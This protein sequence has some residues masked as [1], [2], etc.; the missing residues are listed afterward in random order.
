MK[1]TQIALAIAALGLA[2]SVFAA[3]TIKIGALVPLS[4][5]SS[6]MG[7]AVRDGAR[8]AVKEINS[9]GGVL[10]KQ[11]ELVELDDEANADRAH[12][13]MQNLI[14]R[15]V[16]ASVSGINTGVVKSYEADVQAAKIPNIVPAATGTILT[17]MYKSAPEGNYTFRMNTP[18]NLQSLMMVERDV[19]K[20]YKKV[21]ILSDNTA[22]GKLGHEDLVKN[23]ASHGMKAVYEGEFAIKDNDMTA[24]LLKA[25]E[26]GADVINAYG[27]G[28]ELGHVAEGNTKLGLNLPIVTSWP[29]AMAPFVDIAKGA[30]NGTTSPQTFIE[31]FAMTAKGREFEKAYHAEYK[32]RPRILNPTATAGGYDSILLIAAAINQAKST[33]GA[34]IRDALENLNTP[35]QG[36]VTTFLK[37]F[38]KDDH[39]AVKPGTP[40]MAVWKDGLFV[41]APK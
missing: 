35:V 11:L 39:E 36:I 8:M 25:K 38:S 32:N 6:N 41:L 31:G 37:P 12:Q 34:K 19:A 22:Y 33:D 16:V 10:G 28:P 7:Q 29:S 18:D 5:G 26:A 24:Q 13:N 3:D 23:L 9:K 1:R 2:G 4:G 20:G 30:A 15:G 40:R 17:Q 21:A 27:I 14:S